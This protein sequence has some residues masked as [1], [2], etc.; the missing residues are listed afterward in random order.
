[1]PPATGRT[2]LLDLHRSPDGDLDPL[3]AVVEAALAAASGLSPSDLMVVGARCRDILHAALGHSFATR[4]TRDLDL[5]LALQSWDAYSALAAAF[6]RV[7][8]TGIRYR[9]AGLDVDLLAF[10][11]VEDP[12]GT[13]TPPPRGE[14]LSVWAFEEIFAASLPLDL[15]E[16]LTIRIPTVAG[17]AAAKLGAWLDR[18][19]YGETKDA[20]DI[21]L[22]A[23]WYT[24][25][26]DV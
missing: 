11:G 9:I 6:P 17:Y 7:G 3:R 2:A 24:E 10:G 1:M 8:D 18:S 4:A 25:S 19:Q 12:T 14:S 20:R 5:A 26:A 15:A 22:V 23:F 21:A 16:E 13:V